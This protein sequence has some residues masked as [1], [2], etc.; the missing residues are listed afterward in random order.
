[1]DDMIPE[2]ICHWCEKEVHID[3]G[4]CPHCAVEVNERAYWG[5]IKL[6]DSSADSDHHK[7]HETL[8]GNFEESRR[9]GEHR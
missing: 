6:V 9:G 1:M 8:P 5:E 4:P 7:S 3:C 2:L